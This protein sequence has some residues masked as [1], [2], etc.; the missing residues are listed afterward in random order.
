MR[1]TSLPRSL[2]VI[3]PHGPDSKALRAAETARWMSSRSLSGTRAMT[4]P[5]AGL[6]TSNTL[7]EAAGHHLPLI[8]LYL[9]LFSQLE[10]FELT[11]G[12]DFLELWPFPLIED[13]I[14]R[15]FRELAGVLRRR[16]VAVFI[17]KGIEVGVFDRVKHLPKLNTSKKERNTVSLLILFDLR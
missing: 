17:R 3:R 9:G 7:L 13:L 10:T 15:L 5:S 1:H 2:G 4:E 14:P 8:K 11:G 16:A 12:A 6:K